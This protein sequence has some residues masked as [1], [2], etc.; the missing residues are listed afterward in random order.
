VLSW[1]QASVGSWNMSPM[2]DEGECIS[3]TDA[4]RDPRAAITSYHNKSS[5]CW[6]LIL[7]REPEW[8]H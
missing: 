6:T 7:A 2:E 8:I 4:E 5:T 1:F 3:S